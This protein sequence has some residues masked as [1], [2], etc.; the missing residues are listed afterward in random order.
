MACY[1][2]NS[3]R[4]GSRCGCGNSC[5]RRR[6]PCPPP[7]YPPYPG[8]GPGPAPGPGPFPPPP[9]PGP[10]PPPPG[11]G[12]FPPPP[13][14]GPFPP[15]PGPFPPTTA[16]GIR[17]GT[18]TT[19]PAGSSAT[20]TNVGTPCN[21][22]LN[23]GIPAGASG[24]GGTPTVGATGPTG[25]G[26]SLVVGSTVTLPAGSSAYVTDV[27]TVI[28]PYLTQHT[29]TF[30]IPGSSSGTAVTSSQAQLLDVAPD[31]AT[32]WTT[33]PLATTP[34]DLLFTDGT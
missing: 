11:P 23:F 13:G 33:A 14:P 28:N 20:V 31:I 30:G 24:S 26:V 17:I 18:T 6:R 22:I 5:E 1:Y 12:P 10:F 7:P 16:C 8:P 2:N 15:P 9:G 25:A 34:V 21:A 29:L 4:N 32:A 27:T 19:L 3:C